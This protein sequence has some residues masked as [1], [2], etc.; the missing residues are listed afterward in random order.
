MMLALGTRGAVRPRVVLRETL[1]VEEAGAQRLATSGIVGDP[2]LHILD[3]DALDPRRGALEIARFLAVE[4]DE[5]GAIIHRFLFGRDLAEQVGGAHMDAA[6]AT[7]MQLVPAVD[8][9]DAEILDRRLGAVARAATD[10]DL[11]LVLH[12]AARQRVG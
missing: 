3:P 6:V 1:G 5:G 11:E 10:R 2:R 9:D 7:D 4:L 8:A 12:P